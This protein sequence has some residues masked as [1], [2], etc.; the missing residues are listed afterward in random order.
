YPLHATIR[1]G[2]IPEPATR[3]GALSS[4]GDHRVLLGTGDGHLYVIDAPAKPDGFKVHELATVVP[5]NRAEFAKAFG[6]SS[7]QPKLSKD[8]RGLGPPA[9]QTW[10][11][12][13]A[14]VMAAIDGDN[15]RIFASHHYWKAKEQCYVVR[16]SQLTTSL[17]N[18]EQNI[19]QAQW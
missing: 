10:R 18:L 15:V 17:S 14:D 5:A 1:E 3:G 4:L 19:D 2:W 9:V 8:W 12:R 6:G 13:V 11:F 16:V 7:R